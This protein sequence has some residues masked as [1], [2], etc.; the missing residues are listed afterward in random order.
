M[1][2]LHDVLDLVEVLLG[3]LVAA[4]K[5]RLDLVVDGVEGVEVLLLEVPLLGLVGEQGDLV[6]D[7][8][9]VLDG[10]LDPSVLEVEELHE[11]EGHL[12]DLALVAGRDVFVL[13][14]AADLLLL[15]V[16]VGLGRVHHGGPLHVVPAHARHLL[17]LVLLLVQLLLR[18][19]V[20][21]PDG[22]VAAVVELVVQH[23]ALLGGLLL[24]VRLDVLH[25]LRE[26]LLLH[27]LRVLCRQAERRHQLAGEVGG[28][29]LVLGEVPV[30]LVLDDRVL[31][32]RNVDI[33]RHQLLVL[34][35]PP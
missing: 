24:G 15:E 7:L 28:R 5:D 3:E 29:E 26:D 22:L 19:L 32:D 20:I 2:L 35:E 1:V 27:L 9:V 11:F 4:L 6:G 21:E 13:A 34:S 10:D 31:V 23:L 33:N 18:V 8:F 17:L 16:A 14:V 25:D 12:A 30:E